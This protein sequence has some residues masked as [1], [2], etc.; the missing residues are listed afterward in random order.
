MA[1]LPEYRCRECF[2]PDLA[3]KV[4]CVKRHRAHPLHRI[5]VR[6]F[7]DFILLAAVDVCLAM[8]WVKICR[9]LAEIHRA[10]GPAESRK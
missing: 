4:C 1:G 9:C 8:D 3:C 6:A 5:E 7:L 2:I 10:Q